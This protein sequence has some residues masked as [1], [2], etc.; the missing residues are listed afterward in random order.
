[1][2]GSAQNRVPELVSMIE[3]A[4]RMYREGMHEEALA[5]YTVALESA[6]SKVQRIALHSNRAACY[7]KLREFK[8]AAEE[9]TSVLELDQQHAGA[10]MLRVQILV[11]LKDYQSA[12]FDVTRLTEIDP[13]SDVYQNL[14]ARLKTQL[15]LTPIPESNEEVLAQEEENAKTIKERERKIGKGEIRRDNASQNSESTEFQDRRQSKSGKSQTNDV[16]ESKVISKSPSS[17]EKGSS[18][19]FEPNSNRLEAA[20]KPKGYYGLDYSRWDSINGDCSEDDDDE[21]D[22]RY[23]PRHCF[24]IRSV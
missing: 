17:L 11:A 15:I 16:Q 10:L 12:L 9:C 21:D 18:N 14:H 19:S 7:L 3:S 23:K 22:N 13:S 2:A 5:S 4:Q 1:M 8:K 20:T 24:R 6:C